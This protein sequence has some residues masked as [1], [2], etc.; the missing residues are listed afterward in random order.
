MVKPNKQL[1]EYIKDVASSYQ[2][3][4]AKVGELL[5]ESIIKVLSKYFIERVFYVDVNLENGQI[6]TKVKYVVVDNLPDDQYDD[7]N[8][9]TLDESKKYGDFKIGD[10]CL[11]DF[12]I[13]NENNL[14]KQQINQILQLFKQKLNEINNIKVYTSWSPRIGTIINAEVEKHDEKKGF[15]IINLENNDFGFLSQKECIPGEELKPGKKYQFLIKDVKEHSKGWPIILSRSDAQFVEKLLFQEIPEISTGEIKINNIKR[16]PGFKTKIAVSSTTDSTFDP[17]AI[18]VGA[19]GSRI[20]NLSSLLNNEKIEV[21]RYSED[22]KQF[23]LNVCGTNNLVGYKIIFPKTKEPENSETEQR[24]D[25][26]DNKP[27]VTLVVNESLLPVIIGKKGF[28]IKLI[29]M[30]LNCSIDINTVQQASDIGLDYEKVI[31]T[32]TT[33]T[34][35]KVPSAKPMSKQFQYSNKNQIKMTQSNDDLLDDISN[36]TN[37]E[38]ERLY[39]VNID[40]TKTAL[41]NEKD[42]NSGMLSDYEDLGLEDAFADE[43]ANA[44]N[45]EKTNK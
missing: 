9:I 22:F 45:D 1:I 4:Q 14:P 13:F 43:I 24:E 2:V 35:T 30:M 33:F 44:M 41:S 38:I 40:T 16:I 36:L 20:K 32:S 26:T 25:N 12:D 6:S 10:Q 21:I 19:K 5:S 27:H 23:L 17:A 29:A 8:E 31:N 42:D 34:K 15:Y 11:V 37:E 3:S 7:F 39:N 28:N 18:V